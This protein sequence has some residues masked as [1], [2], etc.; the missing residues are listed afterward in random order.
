[1]FAKV[2]EE[3]QP[4]HRG[5]ISLDSSKATKELIQNV[6]AGKDVKS[7]LDAAVREIA[8]ATGLKAGE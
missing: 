3:I 1:M 4:L 6:I 2:A 8:E 5:P 7:S